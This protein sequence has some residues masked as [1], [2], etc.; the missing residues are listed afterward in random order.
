[1][2]TQFNKDFPIEYS[3]GRIPNTRRIAAAGR[4]KNIPLGIETHL[5]D[6]GGTYTLLNT[7][8]QLYGSSTN[9]SD[10]TL[11]AV[12]GI[13]NE[14]DGL[15]TTRFFQLNGQN[16]VPLSGLMYRVFFHFPISS[17]NF[18]GNIYIYEDDTV[19]GGVPQTFSKI[20]CFSSNRE[21]GVSGTFTVPFNAVVYFDNFKFLR[22][23]RKRFDIN[24]Q[25]RSLG[26]DFFS[27]LIFPSN[28]QILPWSPR[29]TG[30][31]GDD[32]KLTA[33]SKDNNASI[34]FLVEGVIEFE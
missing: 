6:L 4:N 24:L 17:G 29:F 25:Q 18:D 22:G 20:K 7:A 16:K 30:A 19:I 10:N 33:T 21:S 31:S 5:W 23:I 28:P 2:S 1:M 34:L 12:L 13:D 27:N 32:V 11:I 15:L 14:T 9:P 3:A 26:V 8:T